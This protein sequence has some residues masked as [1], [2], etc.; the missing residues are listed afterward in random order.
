[1]LG[2]PYNSVVAGKISQDVMKTLS[3]SAYE[4]SIR[5]SREKGAFPLFEKK[6]FLK[7]PNVQKQDPS[8]QKDIA[9]HG[10]RNGCLT[11]IAPTGTISLFAGNVSSGIEP[12][13]N[14]RTRRKILDKN[15]VP[16][17]EILEDY[18]YALYVA[19]F[20]QKDL[21]PNSFVTASD[22][23]PEDH[24]RIQAA[25]QPY[26]DSS[27]SKTINCSE[28]LPFED[29][30]SIYEDAFELGLKGCTTY[31]PNPVT[32]A[33]LAPLDPPHLP[34]RPL[35]KEKKIKTSLNASPS[36]KTLDV[37]QENFAHICPRCGLPKFIK[38]GSCWT[39]QTC[40][41]SSCG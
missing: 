37:S 40:G 31:R 25:V 33:V 26:V 6:S 4:A 18:A 41:F 32:G 5:I 36:L 35:A 1:M 23:K 21:L 13:F 39:C 22:L 17:E 34:A 10:I 30:T 16:H 14:F 11:S 19:Q 24:L 12:V 20:G 29:F 7:S 38:L 3:H 28:K 8:I 9:T 2:I 15:G 27:I